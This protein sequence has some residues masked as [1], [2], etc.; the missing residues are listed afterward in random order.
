VDISWDAQKERWLRKE[1][2]IEIREVADLIVDGKYHE[3]LENPSRPSQFV[4]IV[5]YHGYTHV[6]PFVIGRDDTIVLKTV[7]P[8]RKFHQIYGRP[9]EN[10]A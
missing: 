2:G 10:E 5:P 3:I 9:N 6:V 1:R 7:F 8:S 4:F